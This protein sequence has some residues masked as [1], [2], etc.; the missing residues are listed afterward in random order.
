MAHLAFAPLLLVKH[1]FLDDSV[2]HLLLLHK[3]IVHF[4]LLDQLLNGAELPLSVAVAH[5]RVEL[6]R[7][8]SF[9][10]LDIENFLRH[11]VLLLVAQFLQLEKGVVV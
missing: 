6:C 4:F 11:S 2:E 9:G 5:Q 10:L 8:H 1:L 7:N 3:P